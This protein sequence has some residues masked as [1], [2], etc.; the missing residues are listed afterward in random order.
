MTEQELQEEAGILDKACRYAAQE[1]ATGGLAA[2]DVHVRVV[3]AMLAKLRRLEA[4]QAAPA[5]AA[6]A[7][8]LTVVEGGGEAA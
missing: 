7:P 8:G 4:V 3:T 6:M 2:L 5:D 1:L